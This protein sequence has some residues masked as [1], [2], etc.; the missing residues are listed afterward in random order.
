MKNA[1]EHFRTGGLTERRQLAQAVLGIRRGTLRIHANEH[2]LFES[3]LAILNLGNVFE[4]GGEPGNPLERLTIG[5]IELI[6]VTG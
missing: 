4:F 5:K 6:T 3:Q 2:D 1:V